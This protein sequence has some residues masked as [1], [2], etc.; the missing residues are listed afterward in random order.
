MFVHTIKMKI[1][2]VYKDIDFLLVFVL[3][4][5]ENNGNFVSSRYIHLCIRNE[6][7]I[8]VLKI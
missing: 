1:N 4:T 5:C 2:V 6:S 3:Q 8:K 7:S